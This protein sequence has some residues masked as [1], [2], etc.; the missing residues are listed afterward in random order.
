MNVRTQIHPVLAGALIVA[1]IGV[2][3]Y[4]LWRNAVPHPP[5]GP[6]VSGM[7]KAHEPGVRAKLIE[8]AKSKWQS[9]KR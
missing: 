4:L 1:L 7:A 2:A 5:S 9:Q 8:Q 3:G 6:V